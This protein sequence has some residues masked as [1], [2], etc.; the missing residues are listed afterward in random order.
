MEI[1]L[2]TEIFSNFT[3]GKRMVAHKYITNPTEN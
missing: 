1:I 3:L 2:N